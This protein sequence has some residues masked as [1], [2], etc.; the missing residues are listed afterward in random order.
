M[1]MWKA[2]PSHLRLGRTRMKLDLSKPILYLI[3]RGAS[4]D[5]TTP[6]SAEF[7]Q[8]IDQV[9]ADVAAGIDLIQLREKRLTARVLFELASRAAAT[10]RGSSTRLLVN[11]RADIAAAAGADGVHLTTQSID[12][13]TT[14]KTLGENFLIGASTHSV[15]EAVA[16]RTDGADFVVFGPIFETPSKRQYGSPVGFDQIREAVRELGAFPLLALGGIVRGNAQLCLN[17]GAKGIAGISLFSQPAQYKDLVR[18]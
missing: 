2:R 9:T 13:R 10:T 5:A 7:K 16:A 14:R 11:D 4:T 17:A 12:A 1:R 15:E 18:D 8:V 6:D 3:T